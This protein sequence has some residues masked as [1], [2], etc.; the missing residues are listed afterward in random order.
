MNLF[1]TDIPPLFYV[2]SP[3]WRGNAAGIK[4]LHYLCH[5]LNQVGC[6]AWLILHNPNEKDESTNPRLD[7]PVLSNTQSKIHFAQGRSPTVVYSETIP[8]NPLKAARVLRYLLNY[9]GALGGTKEFAPNEWQVAYSK[10]IQSNS[11]MCSEVLFLPAVDLDELPKPTKKDPNLHLMYAGKYRA[12]I[13]EPVLPVGI[14]A[15]EIHREGPQRQPRGEVLDLLARATSIYVWENSTI[16]TEAVLLGVLCIFVPNPFL[17][18]IIAEHELGRDGFAVGFD[19]EEIER[20]RRSLPKSKVHYVE[21]VE[22][23]WKQLSVVVEKSKEFAKTL[24]KQ[25]VAIR[26]PESSRL[27]SSHRISLFVEL[28]KH[29]GLRRALSVVKEFGYLRL[30]KKSSK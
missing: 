17:G 24:P 4:V 15:L 10:K 11:P 1:G 23:F 21:A 27:I 28:V 16:A 7:T 12:F 5:A 2:Y 18:E 30:P 14:T 3:A 20:A 9:P 25:E 22:N 26:V 13:G 19:P 29:Q 6:E 8:G